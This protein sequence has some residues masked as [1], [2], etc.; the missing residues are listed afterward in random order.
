MNATALA[1]QEVVDHS[2]MNTER[3][4]QG[5]LDLPIVPA[6]DQL[7][8]GRKQHRDLIMEMAFNNFFEA[9]HV[10]R[11]LSSP[12]LLRSTSPAALRAVA[13]CS[14]FSD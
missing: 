11:Y 1:P 10:S 4:D 3:L 14:A 9:R 12:I 13:G 2:R 8:V 7:V 5:V 6:I